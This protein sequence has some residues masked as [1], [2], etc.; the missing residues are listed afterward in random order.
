MLA[1]PGLLKTL[2]MAAGVGSIPRAERCSCNMYGKVSQ[3]LMT[4]YLDTHV[5]IYTHKLE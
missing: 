1:A 2:A 5:L 4:F 3:L